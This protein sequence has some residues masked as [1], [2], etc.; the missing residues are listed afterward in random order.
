[1]RSKASLDGHPIHPMLIPFPF[2]LLAGAAAFDLAGRIAN[3][4]RWW[5]TGGHMRASGIVSAL[6]AAVPGLIDYLYTIPPRSSAK[7]RGTYHA[8]ANVSAVALFG[9]AHRRQRRSD[10]RP[11]VVTL[12]AELAGTGLLMGGGWMGG[13]LVYRNQ[14]GV[15]P[16]YAGAGKW[17]EESIDAAAGPVVVAHEDELEVN[18]M[19]LVHINGQ[20]IVVARSDHGYVAFDDRCTH[21]GGSLAGGAMICGTVQCPWHG[22]QFEVESGKVKHGPAGEGIRTYP[23]E[24]SGGRVVLQLHTLQPTQAAR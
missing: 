11:G 7:R 5:T 12:L 14:I 9:L 24:V 18:Q 1:M 17:K 2:T 22:S 3:R 20:R 19:K 4:P 8:L 6:V 13:T 23:V 10:G 15:D 16:R 21:K